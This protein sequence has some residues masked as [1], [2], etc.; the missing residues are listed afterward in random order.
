MFPILRDAAAE[1]LI[2]SKDLVNFVVEPLRL[3]ERCGVEF[4]YRVGYS[5]EYFLRC[6]CSKV[7]FLFCPCC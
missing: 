6:A 1:E 7:K 4:I 2:G 3:A 5:M